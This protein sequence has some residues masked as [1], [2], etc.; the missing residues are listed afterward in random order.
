M[1]LEAEAQTDAVLSA[2]LDAAGAAYDAAL[3]AGL[4][5]GALDEAAERVDKVM[6]LQV[7][8]LWARLAR[9]N[10]LASNADVTGLVDSA[11]LSDADRVSPADF[12]RS[13][14]FTRCAVLTRDLQ[15]VTGTQTP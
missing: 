11:G 15:I 14:Q 1:D 4:D 8:E 5:A 10:V 12:A 2:E 3:V 9:R 13:A 7:S 6:G